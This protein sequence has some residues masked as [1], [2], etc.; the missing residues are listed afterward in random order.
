MGKALASP[1][2][3]AAVASA[4]LMNDAG[5]EWLGSSGAPACSA[6]ASGAVV[7]W[8]LFFVVVFRFSAVIWVLEASGE[9]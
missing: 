6:L 3:A 4:G 8:D 2:H 5:V 9:C 1:R 7:G